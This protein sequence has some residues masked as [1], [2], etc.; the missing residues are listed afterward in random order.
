[1]SNNI[2]EIQADVLSTFGTLGKEDPEW[3]KTF[4]D[5]VGAS[6]KEDAL[7]LK[8]KELISVALGVCAK[9]TFCISLHVKNAI[10]TGATR[11]EIME[12]GYVAGL[13]GG[14]PAVCYLKYVIDACDEFGAE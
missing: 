3:M 9:C 7:T 13:M 5:F 14:G 1:M 2:K 11:K 8:T 12:A 4:K 10:G 6:E